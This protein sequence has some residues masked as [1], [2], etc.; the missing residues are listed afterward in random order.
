MSRILRS[1]AIPILIVVVLAFI[2]TRVLAPGGEEEPT[3]TYTEFI[4]QVLQKETPD[5]ARLRVYFGA[6]AEEFP[7]KTVYG[8]D[9]VEQ[10]LKSGWSFYASLHNHTYE[11]D[12]L[13]YSLGHPG[14]STVDVHLY[15]N[16]G[17]RLGLRWAWVTN[18]FYTGVVAT[19]DLDLF[20]SRE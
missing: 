2:A 9:Q 7:P 15:S 1:A 3:P 4:A 16:V 14:P 13:G 18:G 8:F 12:A 6:G 10:D 5:G 20:E 17:R 19:D 11:A